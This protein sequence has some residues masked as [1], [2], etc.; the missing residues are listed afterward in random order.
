MTIKNFKT[1]GYSAQ[2]R[3]ELRVDGQCLPL[4][5]VG[6]DRIIFDQPIVLPANQGEV[7]V[8]VDNHVQ[9]SAVTWKLTT[10]PQ[11]IFMTKPV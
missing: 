9:T 3:L 6:N 1:L 2:V 4:A 7:R 11:R 10:E 5:Q 8:Y